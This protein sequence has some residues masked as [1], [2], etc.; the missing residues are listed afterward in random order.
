MNLGY[1]N[2]EVDRILWDVTGNHSFSSNDLNDL[3]ELVA[4]TIYQYDQSFSKKNLKLIIEYL[5]EQKYRKTYVY[6]LD[7]EFNQVKDGKDNKDNKDNRDKKQKYESINSDIASIDVS[8]LNDDDIEV[9]N[10]TSEKNDITSETT[11]KVQVGSSSDLVSHRFDYDRDKYTEKIYIR[12]E[13]RVAQIKKIPQYEQKSPE[14]IYERSQCLTATAVAIVWDEDPYNH[15]AELFLDKCGKGKPFIENENVHHGKKYEDVGNMQYCFRNNVSVGEY[16]LIRHAKYKFIGASPDGICDKNTLFLS[17]LSKLVGRLLEIKFPKTRQIITEGKLDG[18]ICPHQ[19]YV[20]VQTQ[21]FVT[22][23]D[24]CD[25]LQCQIEEY[26]SWED[27]KQDSYP[28]IEGLS[29]K[30][31]LEKGCLIQLLPKKMIGVGD[32]N[33]CLYNSKYIY[34]PKLHMSHDEIEKWV[35]SE[36]LSFHKNELSKNF[37]ID[38]IIYWRLTKVTCTLIKADKQGFESK[39]PMLK[40]FWDYICFFKKR[41]NKLGK[42]VEYIQSVGVENSAG[43]FLKIHKAYASVNKDTKYTP[44]YQEKTIWRKKFDEKKA[45]YQKFM[46]YK[47]KKQIIYSRKKKIDDA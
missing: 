34:P 42:I 24:E 8:D 26:D 33:M 39:I 17:K 44:L 18:D 27:Y 31:N 35:S 6:N 32:P 14:W 2:N 40:Q 25:F 3:V 28:G 29:K 9:V 4:K 13:K 47:A 45:S 19:Y 11:D 12:R 43:I 30:T 1:Y 20:Q 22:E 41:P 36:F 46:D 7:S 15:P 16:G 21:L 5:I 23:L 38:R 10:I 37:M